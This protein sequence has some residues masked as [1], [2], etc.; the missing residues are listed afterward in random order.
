MP[1]APLRLSRRSR[2]LVCCCT[3]LLAAGCSQPV[4]SAGQ[5]AALAAAEERWKRSAVRDYAFELHPFAFPALGEDA[6]RIEVRGGA[7]KSVTR[8]GSHDPSPTTIDGLFASIRQASQSGQ[9]AKIE[10]AY[11]A[12]LGFPTRI[13]FIAPEGVSDGNAVIE[14]HKF[15][16]LAGR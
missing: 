10:A 13:V 16:D 15:E 1:F 2:H 14:I 7:V 12:K 5:S 8:L 11:D 6:A 3:L 4:F 9:Y